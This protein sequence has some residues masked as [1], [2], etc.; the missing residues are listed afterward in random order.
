MTASESSAPTTIASPI[1]IPAATITT[2]A[3]TTA[4]TATALFFR[5]GFID[6]EIAAFEICPVKAL[7]SLLCFL[8]GAHGDKGETAGTPAKAVNH[9]VGFD[10]SAVLCEGILQ[11]VLGDLEVNVPDEELCVHIY[12]MLRVAF[13]DLP[14][15]PWSGFKSSPEDSPC[16]KR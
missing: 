7:N 12:L 14:M 9:E 13:F 15:F 11:I 6:G 3:A 10:D 4:T 1:P 5:T 2:A 8:G 16:R